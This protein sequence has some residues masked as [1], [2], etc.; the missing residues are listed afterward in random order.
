MTWSYINKFHLEASRSN[1]VNI[2][3]KE[4]FSITAKCD[5]DVRR[6]LVYQHISFSTDLEQL[7]L[8]GW[9][10]LNDQRKI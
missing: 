3:F 4:H 7:S 1:H 6:S 9:L 2:H 5:I 8:S 10:L